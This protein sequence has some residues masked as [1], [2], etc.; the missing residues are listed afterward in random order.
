MQDDGTVHVRQ[1]EIQQDY[2]RPMKRG[3]L[4]AQLPVSR[5]FHGIAAGLQCEPKQA[6]DPDFIIADQRCLYVLD[7][8]RR[9]DV[10]AR[11]QQL[12]HILVTL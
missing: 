3:F 11:V 4:Q 2:I 9:A 5:F 6:A 12:Q 10:D 1:S 7:V 8:E